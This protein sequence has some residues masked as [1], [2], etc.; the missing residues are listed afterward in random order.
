MES[1]SRAACNLT[2]DLLHITQ[3]RST[4]GMESVIKLPIELFCDNI[5]AINVMNHHCNYN[6]TKHFTAKIGFI[7]IA[8]NKGMITLKKIV[9][10]DNTADIYTKPL[11]K[12]VFVKIRDQLVSPINTEFLR[13][14]E[15]TWI[16]KIAQKANAA[17][18]A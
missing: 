4:L 9:S 6:R 7:R 18:S 1:E 3:L 5:G 15:I 17:T 10:K 2:K 16:E 14:S 11:P 8:I 12:P 13:M